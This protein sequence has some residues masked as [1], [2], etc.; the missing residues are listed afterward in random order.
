MG[1]WKGTVSDIATSYLTEIKSMEKIELTQCKYLLP[2]HIKNI[3]QNCDNLQSVVLC[4]F[5]DYPLTDESIDKLL[6]LRKGTLK[7]LCLY[8]VQTNLSANAFSNLLACNELERLE[9]IIPSARNLRPIVLNEVSK[10]TKLK[11]CI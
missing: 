7:I 11:R 8:L 5:K 2:Q 9:I 10:L 6:C 3:A 4:E 1:N